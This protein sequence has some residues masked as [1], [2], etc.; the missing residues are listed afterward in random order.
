MMKFNFLNAISCLIQIFGVTIATYNIVTRHFNKNKAKK[1]YEVGYCPG[2]NCR[3]TFYPY[4]NRDVIDNARF[5]TAAAS[6]AS[7]KT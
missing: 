2:W 6:R 1:F 3:H 5:N 7:H 4:I